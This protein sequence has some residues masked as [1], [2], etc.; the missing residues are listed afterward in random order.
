MDKYTK[1]IL[2]Q[3]NIIIE[4]QT[5]IMKGLIDLMGK[6]SDN[7]LMIDLMVKVNSLEKAVEQTSEAF[8]LVGG[9]MSAA[10]YNETFKNTKE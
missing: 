8:L 6:F 2:K 3:N 1:V 10:T 5:L 7:N 4:N 9:T